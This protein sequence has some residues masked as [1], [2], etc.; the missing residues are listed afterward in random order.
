MQN[1]K[2]DFSEQQASDEVHW[3]PASRLKRVLIFLAATGLVAFVFS[4]YLHPAMVFDLAN[5]VFCG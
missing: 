1:D 2:P 5:M 3:L 4:A